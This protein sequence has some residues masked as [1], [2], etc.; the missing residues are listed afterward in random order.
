MFPFGQVAGGRLA[1]YR[2]RKKI[3]V[4]DRFSSHSN[5]H[6]LAEV[7]KTYI[8]STMGDQN[9]GKLNR[10]LAELGD[11]QLVSSRWLR[12]HDY[13][14]VSSW[15]R[16]T[17]REILSHRSSPDAGCRGDH[18]WFGQGNRLGPASRPTP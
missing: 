2:C 10:L 16:R 13:S 11:T 5:R 17:H 6:N 4:S 15:R 12:A 3:T 8:L 1:V 18:T 14:M 9:I 7:Y